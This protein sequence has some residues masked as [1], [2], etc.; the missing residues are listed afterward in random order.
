MKRIE[1]IYIG[2]ETVDMA[3]LA[4]Y[5]KY[6]P[7]GFDGLIGQEHIVRI[8]KNQIR[9]DSVSHA[10]LF[11]GARGTGKTSAAK[12]FARSINCMHP[13]DGSPCGRCECCIA[14][15]EASSIDIIE[16]D[17]A[18]NNRVEEVRDIRDKVQYPP[19]TCRY[20]VYIIDEV[21]MLSDSAFNALLKTLEEPPRH[22][23]FILATTEPQK[24]PA[25]ILSRC[26]RFDFKLIS[27]ERL[28]ELI[29]AIFKDIGLSYEDQAVRMIARA[30]EGSVR[31]SLSIADKCVSFADK[32]LTYSDV[33]EVLGSADR[34]RII[35]LAS[36]IAD[37]DIGRVLREID[38][39]ISLGK[40]I[41]V[42]SRDVSAVLKDIAVVKSVD[43][44]EKL[45]ALPKERFEE[46]AA[47]AEKQPIETI[48]RYLELF[49]SIEQDIRYS[50]SPRVL[51]E[52]TALKC[53]KASNDVSYDG[54]LRRVTLLEA[55]L[56]ELKKGGCAPT[57]VAAVVPPK[58]SARIVP[59]NAEKEAKISVRRTMKDGEQAFSE[60]LTTIRGGGNALLLKILQDTSGTC[61]GGELMLTGL[62]KEAGEF[63]KKQDILDGYR[64]ALTALGYEPKIAVTEFKEPKKSDDR[65][66]RALSEKLGT[67]IEIK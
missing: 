6:R 23:V 19:V 29:S 10:Y 40:N 54:L 2:S 63:L 26:M 12:I 35:A 60:L 45:L 48:L 50:L 51:F 39:L 67:E 58:K 4:L 31:D 52:V 32:K 46:L 17:A 13:K 11:C 1:R 59:V 36:A 9:N 25:T 47:I 8:L 5:R 15:A 61:R 30:G 28:A 41:F 22:A 49:T 7:T 24:L 21:H 65:D 37:G 38:E 14:T 66:I 44:A 57:A 55:E 33:L 53:A 3:Y 43:G 20:K 62:S 56:A 64:A 34:S 27:E 16:I 18:S 42:L